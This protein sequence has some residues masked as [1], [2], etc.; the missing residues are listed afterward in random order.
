[1][2]GAGAGPP[3]PPT[4]WWRAVA[5][6]AVA[7]WLVPAVL[8]LAFLWLP[9]LC[10]AVAAVR[11]VRVRRKL[12]TLTASSR[13]ASRGCCDGDGRGLEVESTMVDAAGGGRLRLRLLHQYLDDQMELVGGSHEGQEEE[14]AAVSC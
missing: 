3:P 1:M 6:A 2:G 9:P 12:V 13:R 14:G 8:A 11:F 7:L 10:C 5:A 4:S